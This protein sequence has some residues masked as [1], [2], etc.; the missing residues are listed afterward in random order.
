MSPIKLYLEW[1]TK[2]YINLNIHTTITAIQIFLRSPITYSELLN[3]L[4][5]TY[6]NKYL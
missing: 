2:I 5:S 6:D 3:E 4:F 1:I